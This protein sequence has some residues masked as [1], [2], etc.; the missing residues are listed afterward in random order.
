MHEQQHRTALLAEIDPQ[1]DEIDFSILEVAGIFRG[2]YLIVE[3]N[4][5]KTIEE[6][7]SRVTNRACRLL[8][9]N[10]IVTGDHIEELK[11][12]LLCRTEFLV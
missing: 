9:E 8:W 4:S 6:I 5:L 11:S 3:G 7:D 2:E 1:S 10:E 12:R